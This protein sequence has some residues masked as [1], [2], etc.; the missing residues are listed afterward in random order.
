MKTTWQVEH[1][2]FRNNLF[3]N[4]DTWPK[5]LSINDQNPFYGNVNFKNNAGQSPSAF[6]PLNKDLIENK[7]I[8]I[9]ALPQDSIG[10]VYGLQLKQDILGNPIQGKPDIGAIEVE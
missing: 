9:E 4:E 8:E 5:S 2:V 10:L 1:V 6:T 7:G 3:L